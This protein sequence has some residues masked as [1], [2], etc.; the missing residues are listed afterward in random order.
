[1]KTEDMPLN[2]KKIFDRKKVKYSKYD[3][4]RMRYLCKT[5]VEFV[6]DAQK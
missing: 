3:V 1:M 4:A 2:I 6:V 5:F